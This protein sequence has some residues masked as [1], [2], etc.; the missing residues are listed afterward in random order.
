M[1]SYS[2]IDKIYFP[3]AGMRILDP[4]TE[5]SIFD[6]AEKAEP[7]EP[8]YTDEFIEYMKESVRQSKKMSAEAL[9]SARD[10]I[11]F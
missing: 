7:F 1:K 9:E 4:E 3:D 11:I 2:T 10:I 5:T 8:D 6:L